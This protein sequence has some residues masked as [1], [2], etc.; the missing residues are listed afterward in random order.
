MKSALALCALISPFS[1][2]LFLIRLIYAGSGARS[3]IKLII[4]VS[5]WIYRKLLEDAAA[6]AAALLLKRPSLASLVGLFL[7]LSCAL[8]NNLEKESVEGETTEDNCHRS[9]ARFLKPL[10]FPCRTS[11]TRLF[12]QKHSFSYSYLL[13]GIP[14]GWRGSIGSVLSADLSPTEGKGS[15]RRNGWY[16]VRGAD[17]LHRGYDAR[18]LYGKLE[19]YLKTQVFQKSKS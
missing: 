8:Y 17:Y 14:I 11:H 16:S 18:G 4:V 15:S 9:N 1:L 3:D 5:V 6:A 10:V 19:N 7:C 13:V 12:P 2:F